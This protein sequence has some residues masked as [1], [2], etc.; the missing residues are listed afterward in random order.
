MPKNVKKGKNAKAKAG[1]VHK[2]EFV[3][4]TEDQVY[5]KVNRMLGDHRVECELADGTIKLGIIRAKMRR[6][7][8]RSGNFISVDDIVL[9]STRDFQDDKVDI[10]HLYKSHEVDELIQMGESVPVVTRKSRDI[11]FTI[12]EET[13]VL[14]EGEDGKLF[15]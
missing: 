15:F 12:E 11:L 2:R 13:E 8:K 4:G 9:T 3:V 14:E 1:I 10:I 5:A 6:G 7:G